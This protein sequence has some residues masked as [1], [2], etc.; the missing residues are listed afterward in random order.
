[1]VWPVTRIV[2]TVGNEIW[3]SYTV[4]N[5][6]YR[7][8]RIDYTCRG[9]VENNPTQNHVNFTYQAR[10]DVVTNYLLGS[11]IVS[12]Q[13]LAS[14]D[15][16]HGSQVVRHYDF[17]YQKADISG[18]SQLVQLQEKGE[19]PSHASAPWPSF[20][21]TI[22]TRDKSTAPQ[23][24]L[25]TDTQ[26]PSLTLSFSRSPPSLMIQGDFNGDGRMDIFNIDSYGGTG[27]TVAFGQAAN[28]GL[29]LRDKLAAMVLLKM[30]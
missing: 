1:M 27:A 18:R 12:G 10:P 14:I 22:F 15:A 9:G 16:F 26:A 13:R 25:L 19:Q 24:S 30:L 8:S 29:S 23:T 21:P 5:G 2:D 11:K 6:T 3:F 4:T 20:S 7:I 17:T 28:F